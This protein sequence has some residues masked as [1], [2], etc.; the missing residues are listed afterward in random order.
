MCS[1]FS[2][3]HTHAQRNFSFT[4][5]RCTYFRLHFIL[6]AFVLVF[7]VGANWFSLNE[8]V[9]NWKRNQKILYASHFSA[10]C[11][12]SA[13]SRIAHSHN[14]NCTAHTQYAEVEACSRLREQTIVDEMVILNINEF[15]FSGVSRREN[16]H[17]NYK[18]THNIFL[19]NW[20]SRRSQQ[21]STRHIQ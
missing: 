10:R 6:A 5:H 14:I 21:P 15:A 9:N 2:Q 16:E 18:F 12:W 8:R 4:S 13:R 1:R 11:L 17:V 19:L 20:N 3:V 7:F